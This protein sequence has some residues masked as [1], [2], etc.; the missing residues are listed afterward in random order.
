VLPT[1]VAEEDRVGDSGAAAA[2][3]VKE[4]ESPT[5]QMV[6]RPRLTV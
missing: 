1:D 5:D 3:A 6:R 2:P 4:E